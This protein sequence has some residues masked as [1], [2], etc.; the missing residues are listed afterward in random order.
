MTYSWKTHNVLFAILYWLQASHTFTQSQGEGKYALLLSVKI[1]TRHVFKG[2]LAEF[3]GFLLSYRR[4]QR[5]GHIEPLSTDVAPG[6][7]FSFF[8]AIPREEI[9]IVK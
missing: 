5:R 8:H 7:L 9:T 6:D 3:F 2:Y 1:I 4:K